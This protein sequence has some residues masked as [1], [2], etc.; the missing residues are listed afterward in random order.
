[1]ATSRCPP[2]G[3]PMVRLGHSHH[4]NAGTIRRSVSSAAGTEVLQPSTSAL[5]IQGLFPRLSAEGRT[6]VT[7]AVRREAATADRRSGTRIVN[8]Y[9]QSPRA[10]H[11]VCC[12]VSAGGTRPTLPVTILYQA[13]VLRS[14]TK[15]QA[16]SWKCTSSDE[17]LMLEH[18]RR[19]S[20]R[21][22]RVKR[23]PSAT[24]HQRWLLRAGVRVRRVDKRRN[25]G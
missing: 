16:A 1:M 20:G 4:L 18:D 8:P 3:E 7:R 10:E 25:I 21:V 2:S 5:G 13:S 6:P 12:G 22:R 15:E 19:K 14:V 17:I 11:L 24:T 9:V 23:A